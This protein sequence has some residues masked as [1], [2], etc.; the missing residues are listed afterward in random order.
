MVITVSLAEPAARW[1]DER[2]A[3]GDYPDAHAYVAE[4][5]AR[6]REDA[7]KLDYV[8]AAV[9]QG[10]ASGI[11]TRSVKDIIRDGIARHGNG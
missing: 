1:I 7:A 9:M 3:A 4:L 6:D 10:L 2:V 8:R 5:V 11:S